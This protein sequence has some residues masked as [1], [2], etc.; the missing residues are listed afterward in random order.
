MPYEVEEMEDLEKIV[1]EKK[2]KFETST[3]K[4]GDVTH[5]VEIGDQKHTNNV[6][7]NSRNVFNTHFT[8]CDTLK[9]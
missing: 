5:W 2:K 7:L 3:S 4:N 8:N 6:L 9:T 1:E